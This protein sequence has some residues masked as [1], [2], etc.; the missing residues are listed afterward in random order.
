MSNGNSGRRMNTRINWIS[1]MKYKTI[2]EF[3][4]CLLFVFINCNEHKDIFKL[5]N[6]Y[7]RYHYCKK[8][9]VFDVNFCR[10]KCPGYAIK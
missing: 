3:V 9:D 7:N 1:F 10:P 2:F 5:L 6:P 4:R 8:R